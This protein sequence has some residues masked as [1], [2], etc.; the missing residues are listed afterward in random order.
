MEWT[1][2]SSF[3]FL[4]NSLLAVRFSNYVYALLFLIL[5]LTSLLF[6]SNR[7]EVVSILDKIAVDVIV[8]YGAYVFY[9]KFLDIPPVISAVIVSTFIAVVMLYY[10]GYICEDYCFNTDKSVANIY[11]S[12]LH[13]ISSTGHTLLIIA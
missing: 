10:Y 8:L 1:F 7:T 5:F 4:F 9:T 12:L 11:H 3:I 6:H 2:Y 13:I